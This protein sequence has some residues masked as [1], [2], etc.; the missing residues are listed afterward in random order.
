MK[1]SIE[2]DPRKELLY[3]HRPYSLFSC[4]LC[5]GDVL[6]ESDLNI[7][8]QL[9]PSNKAQ[10]LYQIGQMDFLRFKND[11]ETSEKPSLK[12]YQ[13]SHKIS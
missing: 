3:G 11:V 8:R 13:N 5:K 7:F 2:Y 4:L 6:M 9:Y 1:N 12:S 10:F